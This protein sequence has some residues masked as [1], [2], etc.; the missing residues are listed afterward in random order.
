MH[1]HE[2]TF[3]NIVRVYP[4]NL[5]VPKGLQRKLEIVREAVPYHG[6][7]TAISI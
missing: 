7:Q 4:S 5:L 6:K 2:T 3:I 1:T